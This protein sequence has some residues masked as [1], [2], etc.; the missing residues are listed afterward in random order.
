MDM[1]FEAYLTHEA[2]HLEPDDIPHTSG[3]VW[4]LGKKYNA[5]Q[6]ELKTSLLGFIFVKA[7]GYAMEMNHRLNVC[8]GKQG[9]EI[10]EVPFY[11]DTQIK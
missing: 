9:K 10:F 8:I 5:I 6:G 7:C 2:G 1:M 4:V 3:P 11:F